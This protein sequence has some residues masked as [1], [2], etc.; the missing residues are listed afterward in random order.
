LPLVPSEAIAR[1]EG[2]LEPVWFSAWRDGRGS[3]PIR[4]NPARSQ[5]LRPTDERKSRAFMQRNS[6]G[7]A[8]VLTRGPLLRSQCGVTPRAFALITRAKT[9]CRVSRSCSER[10]AMMRSAAPRIAGGSRLTSAHRTACRVTGSNR[11]SGHGRVQP[12]GLP[13]APCSPA[14]AA[15]AP[16]CSADCRSDEVNRPKMVL[17]RHRLSDKRSLRRTTMSI[18]LE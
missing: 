6:V 5:R 11:A 3:R 17:G 16:R 15:I 10:G 18:H 13:K 2:V 14:P 9:S 4:P 8:R 12:T 7:Y 1:I